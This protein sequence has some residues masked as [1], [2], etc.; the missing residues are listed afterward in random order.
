MCSG[1]KKYQRLERAY[2]LSDLE[3]PDERH[4]NDLKE[5]MEAHGIKVKVG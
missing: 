4:M 1:L 2:G 3:V 5:A